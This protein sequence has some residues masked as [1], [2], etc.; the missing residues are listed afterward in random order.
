MGGNRSQ[1][2]NIKISSKKIPQKSIQITDFETD[3]YKLLPLTVFNV[4]SQVLFGIAL[5]Y[6]PE[7]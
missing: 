6:T 7:Q 2:R 3:K 1:I 5:I 4:A